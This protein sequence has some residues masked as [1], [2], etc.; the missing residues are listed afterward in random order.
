MEHRLWM[1]G[2]CVDSGNG[3]RLAVANPA[4]GRDVGEVCDA[5]SEVVNLALQAA[6]NAFSDGPWSSLVP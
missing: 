2:T 5:R 1:D 3:G 6:E 4:T